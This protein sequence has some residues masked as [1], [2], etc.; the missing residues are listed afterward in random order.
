MG[1]RVIGLFEIGLLVLGSVAFA[2]IVGQTNDLFEDYGINGKESNFITYLREKILNWLSGGLVSAQSTALWTCQQNV[3]GTFCQEYPSTICN[4]VCTTS[5]F[6]GTRENFAPCQLGTCFDPVNGLCSS[7][8]PQFSCQQSGG[9]WSAQQPVQ[10]NRECCLINP[11]G[12]GG[13]DEAQFTTQ[14]QCNHLG[15]TLG[16]PVSWVPVNNEIECLVRANSQAHG[17]CVLELIPEENKYNCEFTTQSDCL[18][19][20]GDFYQDKLCTDPVLNTKC[21][22]T[23][24]TQCFND[25]DGVYFVDSCGNRAN[26]YDSTKLNDV[27]YWSNVVTLQ[28]SCSLG[29][30]NSP[31]QNQQ[32][33]GNCNYL[34]GSICGTPRSGIDQIPIYGNNVCRDLSCVEENGN[35]RKNGESWC[36]FDGRIGVDGADGSNAERSVD[37]P[38]SR[39]YKKVCFDGEVRTQPCADFRNQVCVESRDEQIDFSS[40]A[41]RINLRQ[42]CLAAN[43]DQDSLN[44]CEE[45]QDCFLKHVDIDEYFEFDIC[46][47][48][49]PPG[50][51]LSTSQGGD[52]AESTCGIGSQTCTYIE[53]KKITG[54]KCVTS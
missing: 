29:N 15:Q 17:A 21:E 35:T 33:C 49:Y 45:N 44:R 46:A 52:V 12:S 51:D 41:C 13:G 19:S 43:E 5:C 54:W 31:S 8:A 14:Q 30:S 23:Q 28:N 3:N 18:T 22:R 16:A 37:V 6:P 38:G 7:G 20:G 11:D 24:Q 4:S 27:S 26:V 9:Q 53:E 2:Y 42:Q 25:L 36:A 48:R 34:L 32:R 10:C 47:P 50:F 40:A 1:K 39:H